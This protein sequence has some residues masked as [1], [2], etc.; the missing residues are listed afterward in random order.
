[1]I[2]CDG[3]STSLHDKS[4]GL[5]DGGL[6]HGGGCLAICGW[7]GW[8]KRWRGYDDGAVDGWLGGPS[9]NTNRKRATSPRS[10]CPRG[11]VLPQTAGEQLEWTLAQV[12]TTPSYTIP[13]HGA[14]RPGAGA[15]TRGTQGKHRDTQPRGRRTERGWSW[16]EL[17]RC[18]SR[19]GNTPPGGGSNHRRKTWSTGG[20]GAAS[21]GDLI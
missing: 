15:L 6:V 9:D 21:F 14:K 18:A 8:W 4:G 20:V 10:C 1:M 16:A 3:D 2:I 17:A 11:L 13:L 12:T 7:G 5:C 19:H